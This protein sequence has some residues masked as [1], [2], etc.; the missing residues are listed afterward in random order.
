[1]TNLDAIKLNIQINS[2]LI[3]QLN[4][5]MP[6]A[7]ATELEQLMLLVKL[8]RLATSEMMLD[9]IKNYDNRINALCAIILDS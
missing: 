8:R 1:M 7:T 9:K 6:K 2:H 3:D 5:A 4:Q